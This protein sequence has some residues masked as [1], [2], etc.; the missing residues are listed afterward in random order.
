MFG[1]KRHVDKRLCCPICGRPPSTVEGVN[2]EYKILYR[3]QCPRG[4]VVSGWFL[5]AGHAWEAWLDLIGL[6]ETRLKEHEQ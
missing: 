3:Y 2:S 1:L 5:S 6:T 4:H